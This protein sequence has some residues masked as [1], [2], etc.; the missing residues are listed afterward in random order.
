MNIQ[1]ITQNKVM[2][3]KIG[4]IFC[5]NIDEK[6]KRFLQYVA[7]DGSQLNSNVVRVFIK[8]YQI[9]E[10]P[11]M[12]EI[13]LDDVEFYAHSM[14]KFMVKFNQ[15]E[16]VGNSSNIGDTK[17]ILFRGTNDYA[18]KADE[19]PILISNNWYVWNID[20]PYRNVGKLIGKNKKSDIGGVMNPYDVAKR[21][22]IGDYD[23]CYPGFE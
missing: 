11:D 17:S 16:K 5:V 18:R 13:V 1:K 8:S 23:I 22:R 2:R 21:M 3:I 19:A 12:E 7:N 14:V 15:C 6:T 4:D 9:N 20:G 10:S